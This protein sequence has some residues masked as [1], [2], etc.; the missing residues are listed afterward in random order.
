M[1]RHIHQAVKPEKLK[2]KMRATPVRRPIAASWPMVEKENG[3]S[4]TPRTLAMM[5]CARV[6]PCR[7]ACCAAGGY[8][9]AITQRPNAGPVFDAE[10]FVYEE[11]PALLH[12]G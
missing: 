11:P 6:F 1:V 9:R 7:S 3:F 5:F 12:A 10:C 8:E 4:A 2:P